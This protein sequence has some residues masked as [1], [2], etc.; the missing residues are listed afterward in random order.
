MDWDIEFYEDPKGV[1]PVQD[2]IL[3]QSAKVKAKLLGY[4]DLLQ[5][6]GLSLGLPYVTKLAGTNLW[7]LRVHH[8][9]NYYR[10]L[11]FAYTGRKFIL[12]HAFMK[13]ADRTPK[14]EI[15]LA[16]DRMKEFKEHYKL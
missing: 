5:E 3:G 6:F 1:S 10:I 2:F 4:I 14:S 11:Y 8:S 12:L 13:K 16:E 7:E 15:I 9:S